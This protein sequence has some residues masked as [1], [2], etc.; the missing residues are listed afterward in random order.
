MRRTLLVGDVPEFALIPRNWT[1][2]GVVVN[3]PTKLVGSAANLYYARVIAPYVEDRVYQPTPPFEF[4][5]PPPSPPLSPPV[6]LST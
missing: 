2:E 5:A 4:P 6:G 3:D 1:R